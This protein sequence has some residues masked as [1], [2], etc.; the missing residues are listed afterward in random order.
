MSQSPAGQRPMRLL[1]LT[2]PLPAGNLA[3]DEALLIEAENGTGGEVLRLWE[4]PSL[5]VV[6]GAGGSVQIDVNRVAC[7]ADG[8]PILRRSS[9]GGTVL[10]GPGCLCF[11]LVLAYDRAPGL[12]Q[13]PVANRYVLDRILTALQP[14][15]GPAIVQGTSD[16]AILKDAVFKV[17]GNAQQRKRHYFL[18]HGTLLCSFDLRVI[19]NY[20]N[21]PE[22]QPDYRKNRAHEQFLTNLPVTLQHLKQLLI[23]EWQPRGEYAPL[24]WQTLN[25]LLAEK[26]SLEEWNQRR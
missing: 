1:D 19:P 9:G 10:L 16:L 23:D 11:S 21:P 25:Q 20:L 2:L 7:E 15:A 5:A 22:R 24:P 6:L 13:I 14:A 17:S 26:Y 4:L 8:I 3:L 18:H 12:D